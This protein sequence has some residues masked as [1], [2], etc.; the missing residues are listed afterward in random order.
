MDR[1]QLQPSASKN[2]RMQGASRGYPTGHSWGGWRMRGGALVALGVLLVAACSSSGSSGSN[3]LQKVSV[4]LGFTAQPSR[5]GFFAAKLAGYYQQAGLDVNLI[6]GSDV[7]PEQLVGAGRA[8]FGIDDADQILLAVSNG[9]PVEAVET[10]FQSSPFILL[11]HA[12]QGIKSFNDLQ[13]RTAYIF[14]GSLWWNLIVNKYHLTSAKQVAFSG[15]LQNWLNSPSAVNQEYL[16]VADY[17]LKQQN[18]NY[19]FLPVSDAGW[20]AYSNVVFALHSKVVSD[21]SLMRAFVQASVKGWYYY[22]SHITQ[23]DQYMEKNNAGVPV[24]SMD[25]NA[26]VQAPAIY[27]GDAVTHGVGYMNQSS[28]AATYAELKGLNALK[29]PVDVSTVYTDQFLP[30]AP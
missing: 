21:P 13:G 2:Q 10:T 15:S 18:I 3:K 6:G 29:D 7:S 14:P 1:S 27:G 22:K 30:P 5:G 23:V 16:G 8:Q 17:A 26:Q 11:Y 25:I 4:V 9:L 19:G 28:W 12:G 20:N 24:P